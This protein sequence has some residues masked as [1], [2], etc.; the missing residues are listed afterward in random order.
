MRQDMNWN[1]LLWRCVDNNAYQGCRLPSREEF[2]EEPFIEEGNSNAPQYPTDSE[3]NN[4]GTKDN[5]EWSGGWN[6]NGGT[7]EKEECSDG[8]NIG[9]GGKEIKNGGEFETGVDYVA[10]E[11]DDWSDGWK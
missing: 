4:S 9:G 6:I 7:T 8:W 2:V 1:R 11:E 3:W 5:N 10:K